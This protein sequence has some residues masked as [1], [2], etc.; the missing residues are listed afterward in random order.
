M[1][2]IDKD[3]W[4]RAEQFRFFSPFSD[5]FFALTFSLDV[6]GLYDHVKAKGISFYYSLCWLTAKAMNGIEAFRYKIR[7]EDVVIVDELIPSFTDLKPGGELFYIVTLP[8][9]DDM[10]EFCR[11]A[12]EKSRS[13]KKFID[14]TCET[15]ELIYITCLPWF[16]MTAL[17][18]ERDLNRDDSVPR[19][20]WGKYIRRDGRLILNYSLELN[21]RLADGR[22]A[23][24]FYEKL[25]AMTQALGRAQ[26]ATPAG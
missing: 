21:H 12:S 18:N 5:P 17:K 1:E 11:A 9:G 4:A 23:G 13:Q 7:G 2:I 14:R 19:A 20:A 25:E 22:H 6:T 10:E 3:K 26:G 16:E 24:L 15:D 8:A